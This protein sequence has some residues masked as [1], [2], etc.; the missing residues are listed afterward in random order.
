MRNK[1]HTRYGTL[2]PKSSQQ[3]YRDCPSGI[4]QYQTACCTRSTL[5]IYFGVCNP[6]RPCLSHECESNLN[7]NRSLSY[8]YV[9][10]NQT[11]LPYVLRFNPA[12]QT[13]DFPYSTFTFTHGIVH[14]GKRTTLYL[15]KMTVCIVLFNKNVFY[16]YGQSADPEVRSLPQKR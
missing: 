11:R 8:S 1:Y 10:P 12:P 2:Q 15:N 4:N 14:L 3:H 9:S 6:S 16:I 13:P 5:R 7:Q